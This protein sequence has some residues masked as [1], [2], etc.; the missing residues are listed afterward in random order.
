MSIC[1]QSYGFMPQMRCTVALFAVR[2]LTEKYSE[3]PEIDVVGNERC[4]GDTE[5]NKPKGKEDQDKCVVLTHWHGRCLMTNE[6]HSDF[7]F[8]VSW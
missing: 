6:K 5:R 2:V 7:D 8:G 4:C 1:E 3:G